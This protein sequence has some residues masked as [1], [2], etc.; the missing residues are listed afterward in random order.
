MVTKILIE[1][2]LCL[3]G[4]DELERQLDAWLDERAARSV[5]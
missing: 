1:A 2:L 5:G 3:V 4:R